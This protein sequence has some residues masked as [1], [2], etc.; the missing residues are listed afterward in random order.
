MDEVH[1]IKR[2]HLT[3]SVGTDSALSQRASSMC[4]EDVF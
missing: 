1:G 2:C 3:I 4:P